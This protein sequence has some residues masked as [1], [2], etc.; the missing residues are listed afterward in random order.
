METHFKS[1]F[2][3][4]IVI[5]LLFSVSSYGVSAQTRRPKNEQVALKAKLSGTPLL[6]EAGYFFNPPF[7]CILHSFLFFLLLDYIS[8]FRCLFLIF[9]IIVI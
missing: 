7:L 5:I 8:Y 3:T 9:L 1:G 2:V 4:L 6:L